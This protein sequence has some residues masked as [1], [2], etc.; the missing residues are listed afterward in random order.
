MAADI[1]RTAVVVVVDSFVHH[2]S[3][4][5]CK[6]SLYHSLPFSAHPVNRTASLIVSFLGGFFNFAVAIW[7]LTAWRS[8]KWE[9]ES[10]WES[11]IT[12]LKIDGLKL[13][14]GLLAAYFATAAAVCFVGLLGSIKV[15][16][17]P[18]PPLLAPLTHVKQNVPSLIRLYRDYFIADVSFWAVSAFFVAYAAFNAQFRTSLCEQLSR[19]SEFMRDIAEMG[20]TS[21]NCELWFERALLAFLVFAV[22]LLVIRVS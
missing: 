5:S 17:T 2:A 1:V 3:M 20:L 19:Q 10:E 7:L 13:I 9:P 15:R 11:A 18:S 6:V 12:L 4:F 16:Y 22:V 8:I 21:E 14:W